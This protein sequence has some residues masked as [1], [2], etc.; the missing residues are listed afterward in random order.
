[1]KPMSSQRAVQ[2]N[3]TQNIV[4]SA[5]DPVCTRLAVSVPDSLPVIAPVMSLPVLVNVVL[6][7]SVSLSE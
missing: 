3:I 7:Q 2:P 4:T 5:Q 6:E 1:M